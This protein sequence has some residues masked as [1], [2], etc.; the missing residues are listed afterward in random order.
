MWLDLRG[1][2]MYALRTLRRA[3]GFAV[4]AILSLALG[5]GA[6]ALVFSVVNALVLEPLP[7][8]EPE[9]LMF[10]QAGRGPSQSYP[11]YVDFRDRNV[12]LDGLIG[13]RISPMSVE[14]PRTTSTMTDRV[15]ERA[16]APARAWGYLAT[17]NYFDVL[18]VQPAAGRFF[19]QEDDQRP[20]AAPYAVLSFDEW[21]AR[22]GGDA[23]AIGSTIRINKQPFTIIG[24]APRGFHGTELFYRPAIWVPMMMEAQIEVGNAWL[25]RRATMNL[26]LIGRLKRGVRRRP[27]RI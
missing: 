4:V 15:V 27:K 14:V 8:A 26:W 9:R 6:N 5:I 20:G 24:V 7:V 25:N 22:F 10:V 2:V 11:N 3:P 16:G 13:Y 12:T 21:Q 18:G 1:D 17:G 19:H 23:G